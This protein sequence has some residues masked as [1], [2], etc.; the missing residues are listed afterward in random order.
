MY[1]LKTKSQT[2]NPRA[3]ITKYYNGRCCLSA[4]P[5][6]PRL[7]TSP[8]RLALLCRH[9][10]TILFHKRVAQQLVVD[11]SGQQERWAR[12]KI[13]GPSARRWRKRIL[14]GHEDTA[15]LDQLR[16]LGSP[17]TATRWQQSTEESQIVHNVICALVPKEVPFF[18][19]S[20]D[21]ESVSRH[22]CFVLQVCCRNSRCSSR[23][24]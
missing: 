8:A 2:A 21:L 10:R 6:R 12:R 18:R 15:G 7:R 19:S 24:L 23:I 9:R 14:Q 13:V 22:F 20:K 16:H 11:C 1:P 3:S 17:F 5:Q 4:S